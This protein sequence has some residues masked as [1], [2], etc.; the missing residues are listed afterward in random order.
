MVTTAPTPTVCSVDCAPSTTSGPVTTPTTA[1]TPTTTAPLLERGKEA[2]RS[3]IPWSQ[4]GPGWTLAL[5]GVIP[6]GPSG[7]LSGGGAPPSTEAQTLYLVNPVGG[8]YVEA[9]FAAGVD[10]QLA[11]WS[12]TG[13][14]ALLAPGNRQVPVPLTTVDLVGGQTSTPRCRS[15]APWT[16]TAL[17]SPDRM[18]GPCSSATTTSR[19]TTRTTSSSSDEDS[20]VPC[21]SRIRAASPTS[22][23]TAVG[24]CRRP[25]E[26]SSSWGRRPAWPW[27]ATTAMSFE[28]CLCRA[29]PAASRC[30]GGTRAPSWLSA[31]PASG[32]CPPQERR[33]RL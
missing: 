10:V 22:G 29:R 27:S 8:R 7:E 14:T 32:W 21:S 18:A 19:R 23:R 24:H 20:T 17:V 31:T 30:A 1:A 3:A 2:P 5:W 4:V 25:T 11:D 33:P 6:G 13:R 16:T 9:T 12:V 15:T 26:A 28:S